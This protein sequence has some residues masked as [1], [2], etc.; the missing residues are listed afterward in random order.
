[1]TQTCPRQEDSETSV[2]TQAP[3]SQGISASTVGE[4]TSEVELSSLARVGLDRIRIMSESRLL[5][6]LR[7]LVGTSRA[8]SEEDPPAG[9]EDTAKEFGAVSGDPQTTA[10]LEETYKA[11]WEQ[12]RTKQ[13][14]SLGQIKTRM[15]K[16]AGAFVR[17]ETLFGKLEKTPPRGNKKSPSPKH[18]ALLREM[19]LGGEKPA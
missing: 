12:F 9:A 16:L 17:M 11:K 15:E 5:E 2:E 6:V 18:G 7:N 10:R 4:V 13:E 1:M 8:D 14:V 3:T 19:L